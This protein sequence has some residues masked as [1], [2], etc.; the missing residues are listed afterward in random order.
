MAKTERTKEEIFKRRSTQALGAVVREEEAGFSSERHPWED[1]YKVIARRLYLDRVRAQQPLLK[2][3]IAE[4]LKEFELSYNIAHREVKLKGD[5]YR[6]MP[7]ELLL[8]DKDSQAY[9]LQSKKGNSIVLLNEK[10]EEVRYSTDAFA[11]ANM[12]AFQVLPLLA[13]R[14]ISKRYLLAFIIKHNRSKVIGILLMSLLVSGIASVFPY[15]IS[16]LFNWVLPSAERFFLQQVSL[17]LL[18]LVI[19]RVLFNYSLKI[20]SYSFEDLNEFY[21]Q[22]ALLDRVLKLPLHFFDEESSGSLSYNIIDFESFIYFI[23]S[24]LFS[25]L[26]LMLFSLFNLIVML[27]FNASMTMMVIV[28]SILYLGL[29]LWVLHKLLQED[30]KQRSRALFLGSMV[31]QFFNGI[32]KIKQAA[33]EWKVI[34]FWSHYFAQLRNKDYFLFLRESRFRFFSEAIPWIGQIMLF[35]WYYLTDGNL[36]LGS[37]LGFNAATFNLLISLATLGFIGLKAKKALPRYEFLKKALQSP[38]ELSKDGKSTGLKGKIEVQHVSFTYPNQ[39]QEILK[40]VSFTIDKGSSVA[41]VGP[42]GSG[43][44]TLLKVL[45]GFYELKKGAVFYDDLDLDTL[46]LKAFRQQ[47]GVVLQNDR[48]FEGSIYENIVGSANLGIDD[49]WQAAEMASV[50]KDIEAMP[51]KMHTMISGSGSLS[52]GQEQRIL[53]ARALIANPQ[54]LL[55]DE[56]TSA[57]DNI[58]Q[59][60]VMKTLDG[61][62]ISRVMIAHRL[63]TIMQCDKIIYLEDGRKLEEGSYE[64]LMNKQGAFYKLAKRQLV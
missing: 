16:A 33:A 60:Q 45:L 44:S 25:A 17:L 22:S 5:W 9:L 46:N 59:R 64:E 21:L 40:D 56:S 43:K 7:G 49:A 4:N 34:S 50:N 47:L 61:L 19:V 24:V 13:D 23:S 53:I 37:F 26:H 32:I 48:L 27:S 10:G 52:G 42:S 57:L 6:R 14:K 63:S 3:S 58:A 51:M 31:I 1:L 29:S 20:I 2:G 38:T 35:S 28:L 30:R 54:I 12:K 11:Q 15:G 62:S 41:I 18:C 36:A 55:L 8:V 39:E